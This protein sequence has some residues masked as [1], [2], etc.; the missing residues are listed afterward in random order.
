MLDQFEAEGEDDDASEEDTAPTPRT[1]APRHSKKSFKARSDDPSQLSFYPDEW[2]DVLGEAKMHWRLRVSTEWGFPKFRERKNDLSDCL[3]QAI[4][5]YETNN[6]LLEKG[7]CYDL[8]L[9]CTHCA[10]IDYYS[11][12]TQGMI[13]LVRYLYASFTHTECYAL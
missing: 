5:E 6:G 3:T 11:K 1:R 2:Q 4:T 8:M 12:Q 9:N 10:S 7:M 13:Q